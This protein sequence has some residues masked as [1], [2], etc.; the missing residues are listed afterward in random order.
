ME[1]NKAW[2]YLVSVHPDEDGAALGQLP[3]GVALGRG[4][5]LAPSAAAAVVLAVPSRGPLGDLVLSRPD[6][7]LDVPV[8]VGV[9]GLGHLV[10]KRN[11]VVLE[12]L[13]CCA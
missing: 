5:R 9:Q 6:V 2:S 4:E 1:K 3:D 12:G 8:V 7:V 10:G 13:Q 11:Q